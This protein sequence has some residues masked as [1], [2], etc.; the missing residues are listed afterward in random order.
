ME[1]ARQQAYFDASL[2]G[3]AGIPQ[4]QGPRE[5][6]PLSDRFRVAQ[7]KTSQNG[8]EYL[9]VHDA[10]TNTYAEM[11]RQEFDDLISGGRRP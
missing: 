2:K 6:K 11:T 1:R 4:N 10:A 5:S 8:E 3:Q 7:S 9:F